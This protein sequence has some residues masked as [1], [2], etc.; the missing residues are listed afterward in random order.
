[1][2][3]F[4]EIMLLPQKCLGDPGIDGRFL[5]PGISVRRKQGRFLLQTLRKWGHPRCHV[6]LFASVAEAEAAQAK[7]FPLLE[8]ALL[9]GT[10]KTT[11]AAAVAE[12][13][14]EV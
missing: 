3:E 1:M 5:S 9:D 2:D 12:I 13:K 14:S 8:A 6:S 10:F 11:L 4:A 7:Y